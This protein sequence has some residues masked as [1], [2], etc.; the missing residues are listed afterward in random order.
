MLFSDRDAQLSSNS[1]HKLVKSTEGCVAGDLHRL[2]DRVSRASNLRGNVCFFDSGG[3]FVCQ[4]YESLK[5]NHFLGENISNI[6]EID[7]DHALVD[8]KPIN[9]HNAQVNKESLDH[10]WLDVGGL[11]EAKRNIVRILEWP[12]K[13]TCNYF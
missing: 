4:F 8:F 13:V 2:V 10:S 1:L 11:N 6:Q 12:S 5:S 9:L 3:K 7:V